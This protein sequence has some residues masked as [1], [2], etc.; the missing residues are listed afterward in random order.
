MVPGIRY[1]VPG[2]R[3]MV[4]GTRYMV[5]GIR[6]MV[7]GIRYMVP[8]I[9]YMVPGIRY[10]VPGIRYMVYICKYECVHSICMCM[11]VCVLA[12]TPMF[13]LDPDALVQPGAGRA[14]ARWPK[15]KPKLF[16]W[17]QQEPKPKPNTNTTKTTKAKAKAKP[18]PKP[19]PGRRAEAEAEAEADAEADATPEAAIPQYEEGDLNTMHHR[20]QRA[21]PRILWMKPQ[22]E[23][24]TEVSPTLV[25]TDQPGPHRHVTYFTPHII[26]IHMQMLCTRIYI[27]I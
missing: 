20:G 19:T 22:R 17:L 7:P 1:M 3:Y 21:A 25:H 23:L 5:P 8:G 24:P 15:P 4:P 11:D 6:Y 26:S 10:M 9:R 18:K 27:N 2:I 14:M 16:L 12:C 13:S